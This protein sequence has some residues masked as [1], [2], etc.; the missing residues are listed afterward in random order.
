[1]W[2]HQHVHLSISRRLPLISNKFKSSLLEE[3]LMGRWEPMRRLKWA[4][5]DLKWRIRVKV[6]L[7]SWFDSSLQQ[8][9]L[10][11]E[12]AGSSVPLLPLFTVGNSTLN[13]EDTSK[14]WGTELLY[15]NSITKCKITL[16]KDYLFKQSPSILL[17][18][19]RTQ[20][21]QWRKT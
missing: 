18:F 9:N 4:S 15:V 14:V 17:E 20:T 21:A 1:M 2:Y 7:A 6:H 5:K 8:E 19:Q 13:Q 16:Q 11:G 10:L 12:P 3:F